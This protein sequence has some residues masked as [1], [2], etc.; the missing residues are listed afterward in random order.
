MPARTSSE[1]D[2][3]VSELPEPP[4]DD[5]RPDRRRD[6]AIDAMPGLARIA[7]GTW[8]RGAV[9]GAETSVRTGLRIA[10]RLPGGGLAARVVEEAADQARRS[11]RQILGVEDVE[12]RLRKLVPERVGA[13]RS[14]SPPSVDE[15]LDPAQELRARGAGLLAQAANVAFQEDAHPAY[16]RILD[17][18]TPDEARVLRLLAT[19]GAQPAIDVRTG[20]PLGIGSELIAAGL[21]IIGAEAGCRHVERVPAYLNNLFRLGLI[22]FS[23]EELQDLRGYQVLEA[24][25]EVKQAMREAG[26][27]AKTIR[28]SIALTPFG[29]DFCRI[30]L[31]LDGPNPGFARIQPPDDQVGRAD[32]NR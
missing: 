28:R 31:P 13:A 25:P 27:V 11:A 12:E 8:L 1:R 24:Q 3:A 29:E 2:D 22:W 20:R 5:A 4:A 16:A 23:H 6:Q 17:E 26:R 9:W 18:L 32:G 30:C 14:W 15:P 7:G 10:R 19:R 21:T